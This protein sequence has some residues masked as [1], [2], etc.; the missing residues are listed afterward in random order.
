CQASL[1]DLKNKT[2][3]FEEAVSGLWTSVQTATGG[4]SD[5]LEGI[6]KSSTK[7]TSSIIQ[8]LDA[9]AD[10]K[11]TT[12]V[13]WDILRERGMDPDSIE[14]IISTV[15]TLILDEKLHP[16]LI[17][18]TIDFDDLVDATSSQPVSIIRCKNR[19][20]CLEVEERLE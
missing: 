6:S 2:E 11:A 14:L 4:V 8:E 10:T 18:G 19:S 7:S 12:N 5:R 16:Q 9:N 17:E 15:G 3:R 1:S 20:T 13:V